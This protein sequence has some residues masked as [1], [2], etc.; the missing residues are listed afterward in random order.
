LNI[1]NG[2]RR[3]DYTGPTGCL[4]ELR[5][6]GWLSLRTAGTHG[7]SPHIHRYAY[8][9][10]FVARGTVEWWAGNDVY[11]VSRG[12][13]YIMRPGELHGG[14]DSVLEPCELYWLHVTFRK[15]K[16]LPGLT[17]RQTRELASGFESM[18]YRCFPG[19]KLVHDNLRKLLTEYRQAK[20]HRV[21]VARALLHQL[22]AA[23]LRDHA[24]AVDL[25]LSRGR[26]KSDRIERV[27][28][29]IEQ[30]VTD[31]HSVD[32]M[33]AA[34]GLSVSRFHEQFLSEVGS[35]PSDYRNRLR[36]RCA[37][38]LL[39]DSAQPITRIAMSLGFSTSQ[40][41]ATVFRKFTGVSP[42][43]YRQ[44]CADS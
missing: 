38:T 19:S 37:K 35:S 16:P 14:V 25:H 40:Y 24:S 43:N 21:I 6:F 3:E 5:H 11:D 9:I 44:R 12:D 42:R 28:Q 34:A 36:V 8:E 33:A 2:N 13:L 10:C 7:L 29:W 41:F 1:L 23:V 32:Q 15:N 31:N 27:L 30:H 4:A 17:I 18:R 22:L 39:Q 26:A 20:P